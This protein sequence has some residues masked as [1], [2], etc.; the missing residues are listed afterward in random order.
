MR[1]RIPPIITLILLILSGCAS[2][3]TY[4][5][6]RYRSWEAHAPPPDS[7]LTYQAF[8]IGDAGGIDRPEPVIQLLET[9]LDSAGKNAVV[10]FLGDNIYCCGLRDSTDLQRRQKDERR[11][12]EQLRAV[13]AFQGRVLFIPGNHDWNHSQPGGLEA[14]NRQE[15]F[16]ETYLHRGDTFLPNDGFPGPVEVELTDRLTLIALDTE[17]WLSTHTKPYGD[18]GEHDLEE[19]ADFLLQL[20]DMLKRNRRKD[21]LVVGHHPLF[22]V[23]VH[24]GRLPLREH[25]FPLQNL[26][27]ALVVPLPLLGSI[28]P[29]YVRYFGGRQDLAHPRYKTLRSSLRRIFSQHDHLIYAAGH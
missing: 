15:A 3:R 24:A 7:A 13:D 23:G 12:L 6:G 10:V 19:D 29:L 21:V 28:Y 27:K 22:S 4:V 2:S 5:N 9:R 26:H 17:W 16:V 11:L 20:D 1:T 8:L 14:V 18:T 25:L